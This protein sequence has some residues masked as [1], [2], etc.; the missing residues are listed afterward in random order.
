MK[1]LTIVRHAKSSWSNFEITDHERPVKS[2]GI[3]KTKKVINFLNSRDFNTDLILSSSAVRAFQT[4][5]MIAEGI[6]YP[7]DDILKLKSIYHARIDDIYNEI[8]GLDSSI[9]SVMIFGHNPTFTDF[10]N[11]YL[12]PEIDNL[13]TSGTVCIEFNTDSWDNIADA[14][15]DVKFVVYPRTLQ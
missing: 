9:N 14:K 11:E 13:P 15:Y 10:V 7:V 8:Y 1:L 3:E 6:G 4:A 5:S 12:S 2:S